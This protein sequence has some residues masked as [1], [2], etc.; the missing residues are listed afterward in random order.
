MDLRHFS[1]VN[2]PGWYNPPYNTNFWI[3]DVE[4]HGF[5]VTFVTLLGVAKVHPNFRLFVLVCVTLWL[6]YYVYTHLFLFMSGVFL[7]D[8]YHIREDRLHHPQHIT[9]LDLEPLRTPPTTIL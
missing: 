8:L 1:P 9:L 4:F 7:A 5:L 3:I 2:Y 6:F